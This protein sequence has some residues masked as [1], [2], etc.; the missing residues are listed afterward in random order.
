MIVVYISNSVIVYS[1]FFASEFSF[2]FRKASIFWFVF[3]LR[4][5]GVAIDRQFSLGS[6]FQRSKVCIIE[7]R[8]PTQ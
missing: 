7:Q 6:G 1:H 5:L 2:R 4:S 8:A 3:L